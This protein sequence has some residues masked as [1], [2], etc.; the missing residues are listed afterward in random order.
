MDFKA[1]QVVLSLRGHDKGELFAVKDIANGKVLICDGK[2]RKLEKP[3]VKN[4]KHVALTEVTLDEDSMATN[5]K[6][7]KTLNK[8]ANPGG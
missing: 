6:L 8:I 4:V 2:G 1:G 7:R 3:K 5:R